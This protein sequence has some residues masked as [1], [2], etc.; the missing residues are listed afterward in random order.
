MAS[1]SALLRTLAVERGGNAL[2]IFGLAIPV[3]FGVAGLA[4]DFSRMHSAKVAA[5]NAMDAA[6]L[7]AARKPSIDSAG[8]TEKVAAHFAGAANMKHGATISGLTG[9]VDAQSVIV[10]QGLLHVP[11]TLMNVLG[12][13]QLQVPIVSRV[14]RGA[15]NVEVALVLDTTKS[16]EG[17]RLASI[18][19]AAGELVDTMFAMPDAANKV[20]VSLV[21]FAQYVNVGLAN[22]HA[23]WMDV[24]P[25]TTTTVCW[26]TYPNAVRSNCRL[27]T[28]TAYDDGVPYTYQTEECDWNWGTPVNVCGPSSQ[29]WNGCAG[30]RTRP[31]NIK[32]DQ[33]SARIP[34]VR[35]VSCPSPILPLSKS[36]AD[37]KSSINAMVAHGDTYI[38]SGL[39]WGWRTLSNR[40]PFTES[41][42]DPS[43]AGGGVRKYLVLMTDGANTRS[44]RWPEG[45]HEGSDPVVANQLTREACD[46]I[47][48]DS[49]S[50]IEIFTIAFEVAD[51]SIKDILRYC[52]TP[53]GAFFDAV[54]YTRLIAAFNDIGSNISLVR[55]AQ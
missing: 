41:A 33:Y 38:P 50:K 45:D 15:G 6:L 8:V 1:I 31:L 9:S 3:L 23:S 37:I 20:K 55:L 34:G 28:Y 10:G 14:S 2:V 27:V 49:Q 7:A 51:E 29:V 13:T 52:A 43:T 47:K 32:D 5:Q 42:D 16:M 22:R 11:T 12:H 25:D 18:K 36:P 26:D 46:N 21:P 53:G 35:N 30:A 44:P 54:D 17:S 48:A 39:V 24:P 19:T 40:A 4:L